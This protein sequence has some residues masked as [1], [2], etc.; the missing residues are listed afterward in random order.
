MLQFFGF[1]RE[2]N[3]VN[4]PKC[5]APVDKGANFCTACGA[6][7]ETQAAP[8]PAPTTQPVTTQPAPSY[9][10][11][12]AKKSKT[13]LIIGIV[14]IVV[15][16]VVILLVVFLVFG[17]GIGGNGNVVGTWK[18]DIGGYLYVFNPDGSLE[19]G[20]E[21]FGTYEIGTWSTNGNQLCLEMSAE[22]Y[23]LPMDGTEM[24]CFTYSVSGNTMTWSYLGQESMTFTKTGS[25]NDGTED[26]DEP[27]D[28]DG[29]V[30]GDSQLYG[31][32]DYTYSEYTMSYIFNSDGS[33]ETSYEGFT[34]GTGTW[35]TS[36]NQL[37]FDYSSEYGGTDYCY[38]YLV[39]GNTLTFSYDGITAMT[40]TKS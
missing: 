33:F 31:T 13:G 14:A 21:G 1:M 27:D 9:V 35:S 28:G 12:P 37:C 24:P 19:A 8:T 32:W 3:M 7:I 30:G 5:G 23:G 20:I 18:A 36:G 25:A 2:N 11:P 6:K 10:P 29:I 17:G 34:S 15:A 38:D 26:D 39:S 16:I 40:L 22:G 4:C